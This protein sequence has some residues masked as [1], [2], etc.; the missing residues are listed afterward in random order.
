MTPP[1]PPT[2]QLVA[3]EQAMALSVPGAPEAR[4]AQVEPLVVARIV[5][6]APTAKHAVVLA[7]TIPPSAFVVPEV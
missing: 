3:L 1:S 7:Q 6:L 2:K 5:P 4:A